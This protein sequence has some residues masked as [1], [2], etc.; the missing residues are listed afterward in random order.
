MR[1]GHFEIRTENALSMVLPPTTQIIVSALPDEMSS[2]KMRSRLDF[3]FNRRT[4]GG[5]ENHTVWRGGGGH[6]MPP[7]IS[8]NMRAKATN[9]GGYLGPH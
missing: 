9:F 4:G 1:H 5:S 7:S 3:F 2:L 8:A 6:I